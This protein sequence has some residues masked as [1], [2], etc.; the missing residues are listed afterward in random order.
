MLLFSHWKD[1][2][3]ELP[4]GEEGCI[5]EFARRQKEIESNRKSIYPGEE[6]LDLLEGG[7]LEIMRPSHLVETLDGQ[8]D[9]ENA[10]D[11]AE[12]ILDDPEFE[13]FAYTGNLNTGG[14]EQFEDFKYKKICL[15]SNFELDHMT[16]QLVPEQMN[17]MRTVISCCKDILKSGKNPALEQNPCRL[18]VHGGA[19]VGKS[20]TIKA[21]S[22]QAEKLL[23]K[24]GHHPN[25]PRVLLSA[26]TGKASSL[27]GKF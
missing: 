25:R 24:A 22:M 13:N 2:A 4:L 27:I 16:R 19:G 6:V 11:N 1:E 8:G 5:H 3:K 20:Q 14:Q 17:I 21:I 9:Q 15:P 23:R 7:D 10:D 26:F 12:G 18:I